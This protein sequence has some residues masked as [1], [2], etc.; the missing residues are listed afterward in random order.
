MSKNGYILLHRR[1]QSHWLWP[2]DRPYTEAEAWLWLLFKAAYSPHK[3]LSDGNLIFIN[4]GEMLYSIRG[5]ERTWMWGRKRVVHYLDLLQKDGM[6]GTTKCTRYDSRLKINNYKA[7]QVKKDAS[8]ANDD[9][10]DDANGDTN[11]DSPKEPMPSPQPAEGEGKEPPKNKSN[12]KELKEL[13]T[14]P[15]KSDAGKKS[16]SPSREVREVV[17]HLSDVLKVNGSREGQFDGR[18][19]FA[20]CKVAERLL[21]THTVEELKQAIDF[22]VPYKYCKA[23]CSMTDVANTLPVWQQQGQGQTTA[24]GHKPWLNEYQCDCRDCLAKRQQA[25]TELKT[26]GRVG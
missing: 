20:G 15:D 23:I 11:D 3:Q 6:I 12:K 17:N 1:I 24:A 21:N 2:V 26:M 19:F 25:M 8:G 4:T 16:S 10:T 9:T 22:L 5:L 18:W 13:F 14:A 7:F